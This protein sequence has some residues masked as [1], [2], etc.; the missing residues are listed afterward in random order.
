MDSCFII[1]IISR[2]LKLINQQERFEMS[3]EREKV[4]C[5][6]KLEFIT[7]VAED[8]VANLKDKDREYLINNPYAIDYHFSY[9]LYIRNHYIYNRDFSDVD[10]W[11]APDYLSAEIIRMVFSKLIQEYDY[12][13]VFIED[14]FDDKR[15]IQLRREYKNIYDEYPVALVEEYKTQICL[16]PAIPI[17]ELHSMEDIDIYNDLE[18]HKRNH[19]KSCELV[20]KLLNVLA[21]QVWRIDNLK[22]IAVKCGI[23]YE[24]LIPKIEEIQKIFFEESEFIPIEV[25]LLPYKKAIGHKRYIEYRKR[26]TKLLNEN[27]IL[28]KKLDLSYFNDR[29]LA[30]V[31]LK[32]RWPLG[33][34]PQYQD[35]E[36][37]VKYSLS[38]SGEAIEHASKR[39]QTDRE[40]VKFAIEHSEDGT[41]MSL[42]CMKAYRKDK[43]LVYLACKVDRFNFVYVDKSYRDDF[44]LAK[45]CMEQIGDPNPIYNYMS[46]R[47]RGN[48]ELA[49]IDLK[50]NFPNIEYYSS[51][52]RNDDEI[53]AELY[54]LHGKDSWAWYHMSKRLKKK[55]Q[56]KD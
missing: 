37:M 56:I 46:T 50:E 22:S 42:D 51:K 55:Y 53:A 2:I 27:P 39:F 15:F 45:L 41:I 47:L 34:L 8:C 31:V 21:E 33:L 5:K 24:T 18:T 32:Y 48:K 54:R 9:C 35:D 28:M 7:E 12:D 20:E 11:A 4:T 3:K 25:C 17:S 30:R 13:N 29:V 36:E 40:W 52:L 43:E 44:D 10:F 19:E 16:E 14:L 1:L 6:T 49:M 38:H 23:D 26:L